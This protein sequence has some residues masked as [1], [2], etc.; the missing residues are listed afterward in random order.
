MTVKIIEMNE[1]KLSKY[2]K[3][4]KGTRII[5]EAPIEIVSN[6]NFLSNVRVGA[7]T[8]IVSGRIRGLNVLGR[9]CSI[10]NDVKIGEINH[11]ISSA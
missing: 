2:Y 1:I 7:F 9:Y 10:A 4:K 3:Q 5:F 11:P 6:A 8:Y